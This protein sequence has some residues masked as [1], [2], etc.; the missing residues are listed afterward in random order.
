LKLAEDKGPAFNTELS[1][2]NKKLFGG[3]N[4]GSASR[5]PSSGPTLEDQMNALD[6]LN[7]LGK[8]AKEVLALVSELK[9]VGDLNTLETCLE[10]IVKIQ[11]SAHPAKK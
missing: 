2:A 6:L 8:S 1:K 5:T 7:T 3:G 4:S 9:S 10:S 11:E